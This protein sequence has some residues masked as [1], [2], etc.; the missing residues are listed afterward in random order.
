MASIFVVMLYQMI[1]CH[2]NK[3]ARN[4][5]YFFFPNTC[6]SNFVPAPR[7]AKFPP[8]FIKSLLLVARP[9]PARP[10][11]ATTFPVPT[12]QCW[13]ILKRFLMYTASNLRSFHYYITFEL[14][15]SKID[16]VLGFHSSSFLVDDNGSFFDNIFGLGLV[17]IPQAP[18]TKQWRSIRPK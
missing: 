13:C 3:W 9:Y 7:T 11:P 14:T 12:L 17:L 1:I 18:R 8:A 15:L 2:K 10:S 16:L 5:S 6:A 4:M